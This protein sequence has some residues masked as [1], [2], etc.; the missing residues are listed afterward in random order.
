MTRRFALS[1]TKPAGLSVA[2]GALKEHPRGSAW[3]EGT[4]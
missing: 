1:L 4:E 3:E 2:G